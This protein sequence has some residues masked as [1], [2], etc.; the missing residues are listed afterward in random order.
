MAMAR[1][2]VDP[3][4]V[5]DRQWSW[6]DWLP[7]WLRPYGVLARWDRPIGSWLLLWPCWWGMALAAPWP[8]PWLLALFALGA[9]SMRGAGCVINDLYDRDL[10]ARVE[11]TRNRPLASGRLSVAQALVFLTLQL[12]IGL[13]VLLSFN[14]FTIGLAFAVMPLVLIYPLMKRITWWP[15]AC[16]GLT[17]NWGALVGWSAVTGDLAAPAVVLYAAGFFWTLGYDTIYAHQDKIDDALVG[18]RS[19]ARRLGDATVPWLWVFYGITLALLALAAA[20]NSAG[21]LA[22]PALILVA[23]HLGWQVRTLDIDD[24]AN[25]LRRFRSNREAGCLVFLAILAGHW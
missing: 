15:Q 22:Y 19:S 3:T 12:L 18:I 6:L 5:A 9:V 23:L 4:I 20:L 7:A 10:D 17:F 25:C 2:A 8:D 11:R 1:Q 24:P 13:L 16:L 14:G 21:L